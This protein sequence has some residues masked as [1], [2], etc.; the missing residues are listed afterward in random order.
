[1]CVHSQSS[2]DEKTVSFPIRCL[3]T[4][5]QDRCTRF[6]D[7]AELLTRAAEEKCRE[8]LQGVLYT[9]EV[10]PGNVLRPDNAR[11]SYIFLTAHGVISSKQTAAS[12]LGSY[13]SSSG[14][15]RFKVI[16]GGLA[17]IAI[18]AHFEASFVGF[19][20][21]DAPKRNHH[22][23]TTCCYWFADESALKAAVGAKGS[24]GLR[25]C[26]LCEN[27]LDK[28]RQEVEGHKTI[29]CHD[30]QTSGP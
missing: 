20:V 10:V 8:G 23:R 30:L 27:A 7:W 9:D 13:S 17:A 18:V 1:M 19:A 26:I 21:E 5:V 2:N 12:S 15:A 6:P 14:Q 24:L 11:R 3:A 4:Y 25:P 22:V 28:S 16:T 29:A